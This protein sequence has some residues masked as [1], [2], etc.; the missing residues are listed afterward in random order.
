MSQSSRTRV[1]STDPPIIFEQFDK[2]VFVYK[3]LSQEEFDRTFGNEQYS[4]LQRSGSIR[5]AGGEVNGQDSAKVDETGSA[6][7][8]EG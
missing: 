3:Q 8:S 1:V 2:N 4:T 6:G 5:K 7:N